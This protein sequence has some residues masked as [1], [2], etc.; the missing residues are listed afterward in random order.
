MVLWLLIL[1]PALAG[2][3][4]L[5]VGRK[6]DGAAA[7]V[8]VLV[9]VVLLGLAVAAALLRP[10]VEA[11]GLEGIPA[12]LAVDGLAG[13]AVVTVTGIFFAVVVFAGADLG[14]TEARARFFGLMLLFGAA[15]LTTVT[16]TGI[17]TLLGS[18]E[19]MGAISYALIG[20]WWPDAARVRSATLAFITTR[21]ADLGMYLAAGA[22]LAGSAVA[23]A[24]G[25][26]GPA[27]GAAG[28]R[29]DSLAGMPSGWR[30]AALAGLALAA[31]G[32]SAQLP[33]SFWLSHAMVGPSP[34]SALL[35][36]ATMVAA[37][38]YLLLRIEP[39]MAATGWLGLAVSWVG[40]LT[41]L[42]LGA[43]AFAQRDLKQ[44]L[45]AST[46]SQIGFIVLAAGAGSVAGGGAQFVVHAAVKSL[47]F[48]VAGLWLTA[49]GTKD[50]LELRGVARGPAN[51]PVLGYRIAGITFTAGALALGGLPPLSIWAAKDEIL[52]G[53]L[54][55]SPALYIVGLAAA[56]VSAAYAAK[57]LA[58]VW[59]KPATS[60]SGP[61]KPAASASDANPAAAAGKRQQHP[62]P[63]AALLPL[64][65]LATAAVVLG[66]AGL[67]A[68]S[69][70]WQDLLGLPETSTPEPWELAVSGVLALAVIG[71]I[72]GQQTR[73]L[74]RDGTL[75]GAPSG[76]RLKTWL[77]DW[78]G[79]EHAASVLVTR[80]TM[81]LAVSLAQF[82]DRVLARS[83][84]AA[85]V[86]VLKAAT[87]NDRRIE[88][89][90][91][92]AVGSLTGAVRQLARSARRPQTGL[93]HQY[94]AQAIIALTVLAALFVVLR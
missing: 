86:L 29:L 57:A 84:D 78:L 48:L 74:L 53:V 6:A 50:L 22:A 37:G 5:A 34:V 17:L 59:A 67:P 91:S 58:V 26:P 33:F 28:L 66:V 36:S 83:V 42:L 75:L 60:V 20:Y 61:A 15:M 72:Y 35:H 38:G 62:L 23:G 14:P 4:L 19:L 16:S 51:G 80:P 32:K 81:A 21:A 63:T 46:C 56:A 64:P 30:D 10:A 69:R 18:W 39:G 49:L 24:A 45:A 12:G 11:P 1:L 71:G 82:D 27:G 70:W 8:S 73:R 68:L 54:Q 93:V 31:L 87:G 40:A 89:G 3:I 7:P 13:A 25:G 2:G 9:A 94:Y 79:L 85:A 47:L 90:I 41:A 55:E 65:V 76:N 43:V 52:A 92:A 88:H 77:G 44:L